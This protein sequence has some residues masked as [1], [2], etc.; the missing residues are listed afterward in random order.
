MNEQFYVY[1]LSSLHNRVLYIGI[2][3]D[4]VKRVWEHKNKVV[5]G[6]TARYNVDRL[7]YYEI[8]NDPETAIH[9]EKSMKDWKRSWKIELIEK[10]NPDWVDLYD[11]ICV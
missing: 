6:F 5:K 8:Y 9:R 2:T 11:R 7:M 10:E 3:S 1:I 4:L